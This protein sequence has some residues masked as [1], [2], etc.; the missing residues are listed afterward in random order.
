MRPDCKSVN[1]TESK[2]H[3][4]VT[5][6]FLRQTCYPYLMKTPEESL[7]YLSGVRCRETT[8]VDLLVPFAL[9]VQSAAYVK[10][11]P[12]ATAD[13]LI[14]M[15]ERGFLL[16][17]TIH[18]H[19]GS[20]ESATTPSG[21]DARHHRRLELAGYRALGIIM[22]RDGH[23]CFYTDRM[24]FEVQVVG[25][26]VVKLSDFSYRLLM[27]GETRNPRNTEDV[28]ET[29]EDPPHERDEQ[30]GDG[31]ATI[32][33]GHGQ[34]NVGGAGPEGVPDG[35]SGESSGVQAGSRG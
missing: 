8:V 12:M 21:T 18:C 29:M 14:A 19:P 34:A 28:I 33:E 16:E 27:D 7:A 11:D 3:F 31:D 26:D 25:N 13:A 35:P 22:T 15:D 9:A 6:H 2:R 30:A 17:G 20:G 24:P 32:R 23:F 5:T 10:G 4:T 1:C